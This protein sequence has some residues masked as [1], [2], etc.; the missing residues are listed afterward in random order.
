MS[1][2]KLFKIYSN[3]N[4]PLPVV[5]FLREFG[6]DVLTTY[7]NKS[8]NKKIEDSAVLNFAITEDR[9]ILTFNR[10]DFILLHNH[11]NSEHSGIIVCSEDKN[12]KD[13]ANRIHQV[14]KDLPTLAR[15][16]IR[17]NLPCA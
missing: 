17:I 7:E 3:E 14:L 2:P 8:S 10:R 5:Q 6:H 16:L 13:L 9:A 12:F 15:Q 4:F 1:K 11:Y